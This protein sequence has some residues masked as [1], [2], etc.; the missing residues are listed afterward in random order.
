MLVSMNPEE[1]LKILAFLILL[2]PFAI[3]IDH[4]EKKQKAKKKNKQKKRT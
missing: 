4:I 1:N 3:L 2:L